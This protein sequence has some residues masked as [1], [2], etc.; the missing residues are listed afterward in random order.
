MREALALNCKVILLLVLLYPHTLYAEQDDETA[1][2]RLW[3]NIGLGLL[4]SSG[5]E[6]DP[7]IF[8]SISC[9]RDKHLLTFR[10]MTASNSLACEGIGD[11]KEFN[12]MSLL[13]GFSSRGQEGHAS[14]SVGAGLTSIQEGHAINENLNEKV[15]T[16]GL[17][18][19]TQLFWRP[20]RTLGIG[21]YGLGNI[22]S[23]RNLF[24]ATIDLQLIFE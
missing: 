22:N 19:A 17:A 14:V 20:I 15:K 5:E 3:V 1:V 23:K 16:L 12:D 2:R 6:A 4:K 13:Y 18:L 7:A 9:Q 21:V 24:G 10:Y 11:C 8:L